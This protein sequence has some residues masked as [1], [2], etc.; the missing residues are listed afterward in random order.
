MKLN[1]T[2]ERLDGSDHTVVSRLHEKTYHSYTVKTGSSP[3]HPKGIGLN[4]FFQLVDG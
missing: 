4:R 1:T 3:N 2:P